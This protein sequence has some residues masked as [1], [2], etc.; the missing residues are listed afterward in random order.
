MEIERDVKIQIVEGEKDPKGAL[1]AGFSSGPHASR[2]LPAYSETER[3]RGLGFSAVRRIRS[4]FGA[5]RGG[6]QPPKVGAA[7]LRGGW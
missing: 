5:G 2:K 7:P 3:K 4:V 1:R 6:E